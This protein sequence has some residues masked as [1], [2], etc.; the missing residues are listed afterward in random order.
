MTSLVLES[1]RTNLPTLR[2]ITCLMMTSITYWILPQFLRMKTFI[3]SW[4]QRRM[5]RNSSRR[6]PWTATAATLPKFTSMLLLSFCQFNPLMKSRKTHLRRWITLKLT[7][8]WKALKTLPS[9]CLGP[10][11]CPPAL[12]NSFAR[13]YCITSVTASLKSEKWNNPTL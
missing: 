3:I 7:N 12:K 5:K 13:K 2:S 11:W 4:T 8:L 6:N 1:Q 9:R 10:T